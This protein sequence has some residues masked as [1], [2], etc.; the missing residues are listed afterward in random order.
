MYICICNVA[1]VT[2]S[3]YIL[4]KICSTMRGRIKGTDTSINSIL[5]TFGIYRTGGEFIE[6]EA[7]VYD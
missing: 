3:L 7:Y 4:I 5:R 6:P 1:M 2:I